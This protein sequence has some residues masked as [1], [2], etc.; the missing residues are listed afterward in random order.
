MTKVADRHIKTK[1]RFRKAIETHQ[2][3]I[4]SSTRSINMNE[5]NLTTHQMKIIAYRFKNWKKIVNL[6]VYMPSSMYRLTK[7][8]LRKRPVFEY[9]LEYVKT[10]S[11]RI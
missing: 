11:F 1:E 6:Q 9:V 10:A 4:I 5:I 7:N 2:N 3:I 8:S